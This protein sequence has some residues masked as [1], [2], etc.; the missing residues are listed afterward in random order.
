MVSSGKKIKSAFLTNQSCPLALHF[1]PHA[2]TVSAHGLHNNRGTGRGIL[3]DSLILSAA[4]EVLG[5]RIRRGPLF[6]DVLDAERWSGAVGCVR[7]LEV[8]YCHHPGKCDQLGP[9]V[10]HSVLQAARTA[11]A[12]LIPGL[13]LDLL[14][15][16]SGGVRFSSA[17]PSGYLGIA[18]DRPL[19]ITPQFG[20]VAPANVPSCHP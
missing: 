3:H 20:H 12:G 19:K 7:I 11:C 1:C 14:C 15:L 18:R 5:D 10:W 13:E 9:V 4:K 6:D 2:H 8:R 16:Y 17:M